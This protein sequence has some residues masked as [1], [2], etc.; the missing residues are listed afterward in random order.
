[1]IGDSTMADKPP[2]AEPERGWGQMLPLFLK[3]EATLSN[4]AKNGRSTKSYI[5]EGLWATVLDRLKKD[6]WLVIQ[7]GHND[8]K[9]EDPTRYTDPRTT[10]VKNLKKFVN[11]ARAKGAHPILCTSI[12][13]RIFKE[14][15]LENTHGVYPQMVRRTAKALKVP[16][17]DLES[18]TRK[19][20]TEL[21]PTQSVDLYLYRGGKQ[22]N[23]HLN[24]QGGTRVAEM[25]VARIKTLKLPLA[26][27]LN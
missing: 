12:V 3:A 16:L 2:T 5:E 21:G 17:I 22:D 25:A 26:A 18:D 20:V 6:D 14:E 27:Y 9:S 11:E 10:Y 13:R 15:I 8:E 4:H 7:F 23:T 24:Q 1:M 19:L